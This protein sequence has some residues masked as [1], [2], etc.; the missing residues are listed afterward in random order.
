[1]FRHITN[2]YISYVSEL[3]D[4]RVCNKNSV[5]AVYCK[6]LFNLI[7]LCVHQR[8]ITGKEYRMA[9]GE[10]FEARTVLNARYCLSPRFADPS[11]T[12]KETRGSQ[13]VH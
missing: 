7:Q 4:N 10:F 1:M 3:F 8:R 2:V 12:T 13:K 5:V 9:G 6:C 11:G